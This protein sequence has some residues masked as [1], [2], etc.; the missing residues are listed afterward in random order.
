MASQILLGLHVQIAPEQ[1]SALVVLLTL[2]HEPSEDVRGVE[3][4]RLSREFRLQSA[5]LVEGFA[6]SVVGV[7]NGCVAHLAMVFTVDLDARRERC[8]AL[9]SHKRVFDRAFKASVGEEISFHAVNGEFAGPQFAGVHLL[10]KIV[11]VLAL[12]ALEGRERVE[13]VGDLMLAVVDFVVLHPT[14]DI[15]SIGSIFYEII[16]LAL[17][18][19]DVVC[20]GVRVL[21][22]KGRVQAV[23]QF[24]PD[25]EVLVSN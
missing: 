14:D 2:A 4:G 18:A 10:V 11:V 1:V 7:S 23:L 8:Y 25:A 13:T 15:F 19:L 3:R 17:E 21:C 20:S 22:F 24:S 16:S 9:S 12:G 5:L 6:V